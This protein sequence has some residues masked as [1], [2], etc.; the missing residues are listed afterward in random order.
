MSILTSD[1][2]QPFPQMPWG[3]TGIFEK[4]NGGGLFATEFDTHASKA[5]WDFEGAYASSRH[6]LG[7]RF[8]GIPHPGLI[9]T[10]PSTELLETWNKRERGLITEFGLG[11]PPIAYPPNPAGVYVGQDLE[12]SVQS[13]IAEEGARTIPGR[14]HGGNCDVGDLNIRPGRF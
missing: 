1:L 13:K 6:V 9:G 2:V 5:V 8:A 7:V 10:A 14:E 4:T 12:A 3:Y 11:E